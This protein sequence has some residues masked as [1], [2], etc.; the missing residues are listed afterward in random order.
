MK[1]NL[2]ELSYQ[3]PNVNGQF[4]LENISTSI[5]TLRNIKNWELKMST[6]KLE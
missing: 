4:Q 1:M 5:A 2:E 6:L 3:N